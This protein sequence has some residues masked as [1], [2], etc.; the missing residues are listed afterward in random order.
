M[1]YHPRK[2]LLFLF[3]SIIKRGFHLIFT[4]GLFAPLRKISEFLGG[5]F[6]SKPLNVNQTRV[7]LGDRLERQLGVR[8]VQHGAFRGMQLSRLSGWNRTDI[9]S[10]LLGMYEQ[11][12]VE[13]LAKL[14]ARS[15]ET[16]V[17]IGAG[18]GYFAIGMLHAKLTS[19]TICFEMS[20]RGREAIKDAQSLN[21][22]GG[23]LTLFGTADE[24]FLDVI[25]GVDSFGYHSSVFLID[26]EGAEVQLL[27]DTRLQRMTLATIVIETHAT[28]VSEQDQSKFEELCSKY[29]C[30]SEIR[31]EER[32]PSQFSELEFWSDNDRWAIC[33][34]GRPQRG[35]WLILSPKSNQT[36]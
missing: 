24:K 6:G 16:F 21:R 17:N 2:N 9:P 32:N 19:R 31:T 28:M 30:V 7:A 3:I 36:T 1:T 12:V 18:E 15:R 27:T 34:E 20:D 22:I 14:P 33:S 4:E 35:R 8:S 25:E 10:M 13:Y 11:E 26:V 5:V 29:H 23:N